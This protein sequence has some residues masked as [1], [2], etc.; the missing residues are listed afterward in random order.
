VRLENR[1]GFRQDALND[2]PIQLDAHDMPIRCGRSFPRL[3]KPESAIAASDRSDGSWRFTPALRSE[4][5]AKP[6]NIAPLSQA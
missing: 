3:H 4:A 6:K 1:F 2:L 5:V